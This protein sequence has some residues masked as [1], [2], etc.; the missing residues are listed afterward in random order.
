MRVETTNTFSVPLTLL[1]S[2]NVTLSD[3][4]KDSASG[5]SNPVVVISAGG[6]FINNTGDGTSTIHL[7]GSSSPVWYV[8]S[9]AH[10]DDTMAPAR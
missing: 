6:N 10:A 7:T 9:T 3:Q 2:G 1:S 5:S 4:L 8:Y